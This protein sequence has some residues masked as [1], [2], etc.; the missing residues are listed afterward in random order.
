MAFGLNVINTNGSPSLIDQKA[1]GEPLNSSPL[2]HILV[3]M[4]HS[5]LAWEQEHGNSA[6]HN[7]IIKSTGLTKP[8][9]VPQQG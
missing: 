9:P 3:D 1:T 8:H 6:R 2:H 7:D 5:A 4:L